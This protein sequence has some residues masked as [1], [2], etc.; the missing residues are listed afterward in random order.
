MEEVR[1]AEWQKQA[2]FSRPQL[3]CSSLQPPAPGAEPLRDIPLHVYYATGDRRISREMVQQW[4]QLC[5]LPISVNELPGN[6]LFVFDPA[7][8]EIWLRHALAEL[9]IH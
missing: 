4:Q 2:T 5:N 8:K 7:H 3:S 1:S 9:G 6:H